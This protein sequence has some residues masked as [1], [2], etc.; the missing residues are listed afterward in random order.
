MKCSSTQEIF[1]RLT[2]T[3][4]THCLP[5]CRHD[6]HCSSPSYM[7]HPC[8]TQLL[9]WSNPANSSICPMKKSQHSLHAMVSSLLPNHWTPQV[10]YVTGHNL[11]QLQTPL[12][13][14]G[15]LGV[16]TKS[17]ST[18]LDAVSA[19]NMVTTLTSIDLLSGFAAP[20]PTKEMTVLPPLLPALHAKGH[21]GSPFLTALSG[22]KKTKMLF[23]TTR[24][25]TD[26]AVNLT[27]NII[28]T[29]ASPSHKTSPQE[30]IIMASQVVTVS[31]AA[32]QDITAVLPHTT[33]DDTTTANTS[34]PS[35]TSIQAEASTSVNTRSHRQKKKTQAATQRSLLKGDILS[36]PPTSYLTK[37]IY[38]SSGVKSPLYFS[39]SFLYFFFSFFFL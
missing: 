37:L 13:W 21:M 28:Y 26:D 19:R 32:T 22:S 36:F 24:N 4:Q 5:P 2:S 38:P 30:E 17:C 12:S 39:Y 14:F 23:N 9:L 8:R 7:Y 11:R 34:S 33:S 6:Q 18:V 20:V 3:Y 1:I 29:S 27:T 35:Q 31:P 15:I 10:A 25:M 16:P